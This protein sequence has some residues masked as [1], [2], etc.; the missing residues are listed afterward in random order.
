MSP[1]ARMKGVDSRLVVR[2]LLTSV[3]VPGARAARAP[4]GQGGGMLR[5]RRPE[6]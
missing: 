2:E 5:G 6:A 4:S 3:P 1:A